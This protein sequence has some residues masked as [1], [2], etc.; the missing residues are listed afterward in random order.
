MEHLELNYKVRGNGSPLI[1]IHGLYGCL[2][3]WV[4]VAKQLEPY[5]T[6]IVIDLRGHGRSKSNGVLTYLDMVN[7]IH[8]LLVKLGIT[9][10]SIIGH[11]MGGKVAMLLKAIYP[12]LITKLIIIDIFPKDYSSTEI[13]IKHNQI[14]NSL[15]EIDLSTNREEIRLQLEEKLNDPLFAKFMLK[16]IK[17]V[18]KEMNW[19]LDLYAIKS[20]IK[21]ICSDVVA[22]QLS[23]LSDLN[24]WDIS[25]IRGDRSNY[26]LDSDI[27][28]SKQLFNNPKTYTI[29]NSSHWIHYDNPHQ[30]TETI[31]DISGINAQISGPSS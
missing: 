22:D 11:S 24:L 17:R 23:V 30:L 2:D 7:D 12:D 31:L 15:L 20:D 16:N 21:Q 18:N 3:N 14:I 19:K 1:I 27:D 4:A 8:Y 28:R 9:S 10:L 26:I 5:F 6:T 25:F 29:S 13:P